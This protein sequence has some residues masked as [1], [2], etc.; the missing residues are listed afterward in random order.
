M[1]RQVSYHKLIFKTVP[2]TNLARVVKFKF[3]TIPFKNKTPPE[4]I[5]GGVLDSSHIILSFS[6][7]RH[8]LKRSGWGW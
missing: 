1:L 4:D 8:I 3:T 2:G 7:I 6:Y 5:S